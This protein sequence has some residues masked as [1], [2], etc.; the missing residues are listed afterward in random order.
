MT[1]KEGKIATPYK[2]TSQPLY[3]ESFFFKAHNVFYA[4]RVAGG[5]SVFKK[6]FFGSLRPQFGLK[7]RGRG[8]A[9][10]APPWTRH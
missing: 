8:R 1:V 3:Q 4:G 9:P 2:A 6:I 7:I 5:G 10:W